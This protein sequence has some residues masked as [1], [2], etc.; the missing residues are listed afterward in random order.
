MK[1]LFNNTLVT[2]VDYGVLIILNLLATPILIQQF[3]ID[4]YGAFVFLSVFSIYGAMLFFDLGMEGSLMNYVARFHASGDRRRLHG[5][6]SVSVIY[7][8]VLG[9]L[10]AVIL[11]FASGLIADR[12]LKDSATV[13][14]D[15]VLNALAVVCVNVFFQFLTV[16]LVAVLQGMG[17]YGVTKPLNCVANIL[18]YLLL[19]AVAIYYGRIDIAYGV[20]AALTVFRL[21]VLLLLL[22]GRTPEFSGFRGVLDPALFR[23]LFRYSSILFVNRAVG[24]ICNQI[25]KV[26]I[27]AMLVVRSMA[28]YDVIARPSMV[29]RVILSVANGAVVPEVSRLHELGD[30]RAIWKIYV[31]IVRYIYMF[32]LPLLAAAYVYMDDV[33]RLWV[34]DEFAAYAPAALI[35]LSTY[36]VLPIPSVA[37][38]VV[39]GLEKVRQTIWIPVV[40]TVINAGL[41]LLLLQFM[42]LAGLVT[43]TLV[44]EAFA[45][46]PYAAAMNRLVHGSWTELFRPILGVAVA[47]AAAF[48]VHLLIDS[49]SEVALVKAGLSLVVVTGGW[50]LNYRVML[51]SSE[52]SFVSERMR[53]YVG[54]VSRS[55]GE[56]ERLRA[57]RTVVP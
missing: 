8:G 46:I 13:P 36:L 53:T 20:V 30:K 23:T 16:P 43:A 44:A 52:R 28:I 15:T 27:W 25:D 4:G 3:G 1:R 12:L 56:R 35:L 38:T 48:C 55:A 37:S 9:L 39:V 50:L 24:L 26:L 54:T 17:R 21:F 11:Y 22:L 33:L 5:C 32:L 41:S 18:R 34:G 6:L 45:V 51:N 29:L 7:Y 42:G 31:N 10:L 19:I 2:A 47:A 40:S 14:H 49:A 57:E